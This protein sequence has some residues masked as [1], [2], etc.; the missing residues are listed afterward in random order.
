MENIVNRMDNK[1]IN[2]FPTINVYTYIYLH[3]MSHESISYVTC[4]ESNLQTKHS[5]IIPI[6]P[7]GSHYVKIFVTTESKYIIKIFIMTKH[8]YLQVIQ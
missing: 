4:I 2:R 3:Y 8:N 6:F 1:K 7:T 5:Q